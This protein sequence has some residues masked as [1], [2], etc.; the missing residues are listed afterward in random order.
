MLTSRSRPTGKA[1]CHPRV[2]LALSAL[3][4]VS[5]ASPDWPAA[6]PLSCAVTWIRLCSV[7]R[8]WRVALTNPHGALA[9]TDSARQQRMRADRV[10]IAVRGVSHASTDGTMGWRSTA[11]AVCRPLRFCCVVSFF[12]SSVASVA[13]HAHRRRRRCWGRMA[14]RLSMEMAAA[15][16]RRQLASALAVSVSALLCVRRCFFSV[17]ASLF[18]ASPSPIGK[19]TAEQPTQSESHSRLH[20]AN[21]QDTR[22]DDPTLLPPRLC[23][24]CSSPRRPPPH[25]PLLPIGAP[26]SHACNPQRHIRPTGQPQH[27][28]VAD[29]SIRVVSSSAICSS[30]LERRAESGGR[31]EQSKAAEERKR[32]REARHSFGA[33][34]SV[35][36]C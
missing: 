19:R 13:S 27:T 36:V 9:A 17:C 11:I 12:S 26:I 30:R 24:C 32:E 15:S 31:A 34:V 6:V 33:L 28:H 29:A 14:L 20:N 5:S 21:R 10:R 16:H 22:N 1:D 25:P 4:A 23:L 18:S 7:R 3:S 8:V 35:S 2:A